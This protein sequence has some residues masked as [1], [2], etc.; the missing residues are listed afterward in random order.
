MSTSSRRAVAWP[1]PVPAVTD[2]LRLLAAFALQS[3][4]PVAL[5]RLPNAE[6]P[7]LCLSFSAEDAFTGLPPALEPTAPAGFAFF[8]FHDSDHNPALFLPAD[9][10][11]SAERPH[12][13][14]ISDEAH[15]SSQLSDLLVFISK[16][17][18]CDFVSWYV[19]PQP[20]PHIADQ[21]EFSAL[22]TKGVEA[23]EQGAVV[24]VVPSRAATRPLPPAFDTLEAF[25]ELQRRYPRAFVS[26]VSAQGIGTWLGATPEVLV[27]IG[28]DGRFCTMAL[29]GTQPIVDGLTPQNAI[30]RQKEIEEQ[31]LVARYVVSCF[32]QL[33]LREYTETGPRT[34]AAGELLHLR[35]DFSVN[36]RQVPFPT[37]GTDML[38]LL[39]PTSA[40]GGMPKQAALT[41]LHQH[42]HYDRAYYS[43]FLGPVN[44]PQTGVSRLFVNLRCLQVRPTQAILYAG[45]GLTIDSDPLREWNETELKLRTA[46]AVLD[47]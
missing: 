22:V 38:R 26:L 13:L 24:K 29:A 41:F 32:K 1:G 23:I 7:Q 45:A 47:T 40:V 20:I 44:L 14:D 39:H 3:G 30:W 4:L 12:E 16:P 19:S 11:F 15:L 5:W 33:R 43:G 31:A 9:V 28:E 21:A 46:G 27:E 35:T 36:L 2:Q 10:V 42:E 25:E 6:H 17:D 18:S 8:P 37:L 34:V